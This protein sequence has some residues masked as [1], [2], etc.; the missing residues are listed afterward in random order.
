MKFSL[1]V[2]TYGTRIDEMRRLFDSITKQT[3][4]NFE[5][6]V[7]SQVNHDEVSKLLSGYDF[8]YKHI[9]LEGK[10]VSKSRNGIM[11]YATGDVYTF[12]DDDCWYRENTLEVVK[13]YFEKYNPD[14]A[15]FQH[16]DPELN[17]STTVYAENE[18]LGLSKMKVLK[19]IT[20]DMWFNA[21]TV[22]PKV[23]RFDE[24]FGVGTKYS[25]GE[26]NV[27]VM[28]LYNEGDKK[29][30]YFPELI[31]YHPYKAVNYIDKDA[32]LGKGPLFKRLFGGFSGFFMFIAF[33]L[34]KRR[35]IKENCDGKFMSVVYPAIV[36]QLK[37]K[38]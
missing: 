23:R 20:F 21:K 36:E 33:C 35:M 6:I 27:F 38:I 12:T 29:L 16:K 28:E 13:S 24:R 26:E 14:M 19:V 8:D 10:G 34:K 3:Y 11:G 30:Y 18:I 7:G 31:T 4:K 1:L 2:G 32:I 9:R 17:K 5:V 15:C 25:S 22:D 37:F